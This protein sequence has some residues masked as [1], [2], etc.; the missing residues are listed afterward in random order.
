MKK[1]RI[2]HKGKPICISISAVKAHLVHGDSYIGDC[3]LKSGHGKNLKSSFVK[4]TNDMFPKNDDIRI[5]PIPA[6]DKITIQLGQ[7]T[8]NLKYLKLVNTTG[9]IIK[10]IQIDEQKEIVI[11]RG[12]L[13]KGVYLLLFMGERAITEKIILN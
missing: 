2:C 7:N 6:T 10:S 13:D 11:E 1:V 4:D 9:R 12:E 8:K 3:N 5:F